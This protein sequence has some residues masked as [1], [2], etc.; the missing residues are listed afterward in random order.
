MFLAIDT[1]FAQCSVALLEADGRVVFEQTLPSDR[2]QTQQI[3]PMIQQAFLEAGI[4]FADLTAL[5]FNRGPG[6][7]SGIRINTAVTQAIAFSHDLPCVGVSSLAVLAQTALQVNHK[8]NDVYVA[9]DA[10][11]KQVYFAHYQISD[12]LDNHKIMQLVQTEQ[13]ENLLDYE[14][15]TPKDLPIVGNGAELLALHPNQHTL[16][17]LTPNAVTLAKL[18]MQ[19]YKQFGG[20]T[21]EN[22]LPVYV[23][24]NA[25]KTLA[26]QGK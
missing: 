18:G 25:W 10:R 16:P 2:R 8:L 11:M 24:N 6:A 9:F 13:G 19:H 4:A 21:A 22:A 17:D 12:K 20:V 1:V 26:E 15:S 7:F 23:R 14:Q 5:I 3:L